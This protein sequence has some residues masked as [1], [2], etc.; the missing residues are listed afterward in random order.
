MHRKALGMNQGSDE[1]EKEEAEQVG[2]RV[3]VIS[4]VFIGNDLRNMST[5]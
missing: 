2:S 4:K 5:E 3:G 1:K